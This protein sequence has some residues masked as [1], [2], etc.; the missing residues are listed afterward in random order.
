[1]CIRDSDNSIGLWHIQAL[2]ACKH[3]GLWE[4]K[5]FTAPIRSALDYIRKTQASDGGIGYKSASP[6]KGEVGYTMTGGG[7]LAYQ[8]WGKSH[9]SVVRKGARYIEKNAKFEYNTAHSD[10]Y[11]HYYHAQAM[12]NR[13]GAD[14]EFY[15]KLF[16]DELLKNQNEDGSWKNVGGGEKVLGVAAQFQGGSAKAVHYRT[17]L[18]TLMLEVYYRFLPATGR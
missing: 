8:M 4:D 6:H 11:R 1:M 18:A 15:N 9:D 16:R 17:C 2:K 13:G 10:L 3:T 14:W 5:V 12:I 7:M